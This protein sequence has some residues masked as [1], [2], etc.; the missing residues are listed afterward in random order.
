MISRKNS[1]KNFGKASIENL[2]QEALYMIARQISPQGKAEAADLHQN[3]RRTHQLRN[4]GASMDVGTK[5]RSG[6]FQRIQ[7][8]DE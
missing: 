4:T 2:V 5:R 6:T 7:Q 3:A 8:P 1:P